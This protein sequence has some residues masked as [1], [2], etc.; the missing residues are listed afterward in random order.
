MKTPLKRSPF[1]L[2]QERLR[3]RPWALLVGCVLYNRTRG[4]HAWPVLWSFLADWRSPENVV[5]EYQADP[6]DVLDLLEL[7]FATLGFMRRRAKAVVAL[8]H[9]FIGFDLERGD[10]ERLPGCGRYAA[11]SFEIFVRGRLVPKPQDKELRRYVQWA[12]AQ[13]GRSHT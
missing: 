4:E 11:E 10:V 12:R 9:A 13:G 8:S 3:R 1:D 2:M 5:D 7:R 6:Q